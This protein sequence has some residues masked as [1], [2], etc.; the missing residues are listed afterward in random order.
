ML[1]LVSTSRDKDEG[2]DAC[3]SDPAGEAGPS[4][5]HGA[6]QP[7]SGVRIS[8]RPC[9]AHTTLTGGATITDRTV[10]RSAQ[11]F[12]RATCRV[13]CLC[14]GVQQHLASRIPLWSADTGKHPPQ[15]PEFQATGRR[16][17]YCILECPAE[18]SPDADANTGPAVAGD[19][20]GLGPALALGNLAAAKRPAQRSSS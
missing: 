13:V 17:E 18:R 14:F 10:R 1:H 3:G 2:N 15:E 16:W 5:L 6:Q 9:V 8:E 20:V 7:G 11:H 4:R 19:G 12:A